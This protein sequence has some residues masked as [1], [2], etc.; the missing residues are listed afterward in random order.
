MPIYEYYC[1]DC[2]QQVDLFFK[3]FAEVGTKKPICPTCHGPHLTRLVSQVTRLHHAT[4]P[5]PAGSAPT[6]SEKRES[7]QDLAAMM[8]QAQRKTGQGLGREFNEVAKRLER[9]EN[10]A[11]VEQSL[12]RR[13]GQ[14]KQVH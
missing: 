14:D 8:Q 12:R 13:A 7:P 3:S 2:D 1:E 10:A 4:H 11:S 6:P 9:G 5:Q